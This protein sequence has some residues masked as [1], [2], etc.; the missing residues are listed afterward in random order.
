MA[1]IAE[2][3]QE[4]S[5][6]TNSP[7]I[8]ENAP[9]ECNFDGF[10]GQNVFPNRSSP[11]VFFSLQLHSTCTYV[12]TEGTKT[13]I[14]V[15]TSAPTLYVAA[16]ASAT[17]AVSNATSASFTAHNPSIVQSHRAHAAGEASAAST[18]F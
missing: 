7:P 2:E 3:N 16:K 17:K 6:P 8:D 14:S 5:H 1:N 10:S 12:F 9:L 4:Y 13:S 11:E 15:H 18:T